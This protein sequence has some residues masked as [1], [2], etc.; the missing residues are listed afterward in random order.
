MATK[1]ARTLPAVMLSATT[2]PQVSD[3]YVGRI[4]DRAILDIYQDIDK[5]GVRDGLPRKMILE[6]TFTP[7]SEGRVKID[8]QVKTKLPSYRPEVTVAK[9]DANGAG[10][11]F[12][13][14]CA[15]NPDQLTMIPEEDDDK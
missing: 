8:S 10:L 12:S 14:D 9:L 6:V 3:G 5:R 13:P 7:G 11:L 2:L 1:R 4:M 15:E